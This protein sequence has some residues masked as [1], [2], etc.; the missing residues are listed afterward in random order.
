MIAVVVAAC[1]SDSASPDT[2]DVPIASIESG[3]DEGDAR[4]AVDVALADSRLD[5]LLQ[6]QSFEVTE[7]RSPLDAPSGLVVAIRFDEPLDADTEYPLDVCS[8]D[9]GGAP[10]TGVL[11]LVDG[12]DISAVSPQWGDDIACGF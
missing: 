3:V 1:G 10:I 7:V 11:W 2:T 4:A 6:G 5:E 9:T 8:V 12:S